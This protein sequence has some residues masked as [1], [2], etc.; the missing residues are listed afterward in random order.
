MIVNGYV[1]QVNSALKMLKYQ[2][3]VKFL[4]VDVSAV[5]IETNV[6]YDSTDEILY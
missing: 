4:S 6:I 3:T 5:V 1:S 2:I